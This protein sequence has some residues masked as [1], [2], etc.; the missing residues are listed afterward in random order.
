STYPVTAQGRNVLYY[1]HSRVGDQPGYPRDHGTPANNLRWFRMGFDYNLAR[2]CNTWRAPAAAGS[3]PPPARR[4]RGRPA[5]PLSPG[6]T[7]SSLVIGLPSLLPG[8]EG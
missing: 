2:Q 4:S 8:V 3:C 1:F 6:V 7:G 5:P